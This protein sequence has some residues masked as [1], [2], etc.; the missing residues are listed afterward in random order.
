MNKL[1]IREGRATMNSRPIQYKHSNNSSNSVL[2][3]NLDGTYLDS[4][5]TQSFNTL[6]N[7]KFI[8]IV[9]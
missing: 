2:L 5:S 1:L 8:T 6:V 9:D 4:I 3:Y 7:D